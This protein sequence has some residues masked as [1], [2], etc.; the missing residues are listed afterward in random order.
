MPA[1][2]NF[3]LRRILVIDTLCDDPLLHSV[4]RVETRPYKRHEPVEE[5]W[6]TPC[7]Q[8]SSASPVKAA[9]TTG[10]SHA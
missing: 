8:A 5:Y 7:R 1:M 10:T 2:P 4:G 9:A 6:R 3:S